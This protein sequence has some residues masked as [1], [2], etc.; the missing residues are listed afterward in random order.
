MDI[1]A[2]LEKEF[3]KKRKTGATA[4]LSGSNNAPADPA[5]PKSSPGEASTDKSESE[6]KDKEA[7]AAKAKAK[8]ADD[9]KKLALQHLKEGKSFTKE[10]A[11]FA[12]KTYAEAAKSAAGDKPSS[13]QHCR[14]SHTGRYEPCE[15]YSCCAAFQ[16]TCIS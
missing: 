3:P 10:A 9:I 4:D 1:K 12:P 8:R 15:R 6:A 11:Q 16:R 14:P 7:E 13:G 5:D 2:N